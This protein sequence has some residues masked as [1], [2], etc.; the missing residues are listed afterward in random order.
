MT[1]TIAFA[2]HQFGY[3]VCRHRAFSRL[4]VDAPQHRSSSTVGSFI[5]FFVATVMD[6][7]G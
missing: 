3:P 7:S 1:P 4:C 2:H 5:G 6:D